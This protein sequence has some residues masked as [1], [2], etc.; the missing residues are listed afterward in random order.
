MQNNSI[1]LDAQNDPTFRKLGSFLKEKV[2]VHENATKVFKPLQVIYS[3]HLRQ[4]NRRYRTFGK[5]VVFFVCN[6][7]TS[8]FESIPFTY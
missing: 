2:D 6:I 3:N 7:K 1:L 5:S 8:R 4:L